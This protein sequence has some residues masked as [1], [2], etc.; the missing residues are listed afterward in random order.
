M[1]S[2]E[3]TVAKIL[4]TST[5]DERVAQIR[6]IPQR[7]GTGEHPGIYADVARIAYVPQLAPDF[8]YIHAADF[9]ELPTFEVAY[10]AAAAA[11]NN[12][13]DVTPAVLAATI[14]TNPTTLLVFRTI[15]GFTKTEFAHC[16]SLVGE[17]HDLKLSG[18]KVDSM[19]REGS[20]TT[21]QQAQLVADTIT[22]VMAGTLFGDPPGELRRKQTKPDT[23]EGWATVNNLAEEG[24]PYSWLLHQRHYGG[25]FRQILDA[26]STKRGDLIED[27]VEQLFQD[28]QI[29]YLRTG[30]H[31]QGDI[32]AQ[33]EILVTPA[34]DFVI[35]DSSGT[36]RAIMECKTI[37]DGGTA[38]DKA[39]RFERLRAEANRLGGI[40]LLAVLGG[41]GWTRVND[42][43][44]PVVRDTDGRV[45]TLS[46]LDEMLTVAPFPSLI[47]TVTPGSD[48][49]TDG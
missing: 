43:L 45:F 29:P 14:Q 5:W 47:G 12:F 38:R 22:Q 6:L 48:V 26:T 33:F 27:V 1:S 30:S 9:Y 4:H 35:F 37:N 13:Q 7:H 17:S 10:A 34:P 44:G 24:A 23:A 18:A 20:V 49:D 15:L 25:A 32:M 41:L 46:N 40:P 39:L 11:T 3:E 21:P 42:T 28:N 8:A 2:A 19:E 16:T 36:L 31:N